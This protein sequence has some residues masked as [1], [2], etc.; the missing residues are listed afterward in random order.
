[1]KNKPSEKEIAKKATE[2][3]NSSSTYEELCWLI[4]ELSKL[5]EKEAFS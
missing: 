5:K 1:M 4:A 2:I 3:H